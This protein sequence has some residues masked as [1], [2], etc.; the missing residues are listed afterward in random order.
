M[1]TQSPAIMMI[2]MLAT[3]KIQRTRWVRP[4]LRLLRVAHQLMLE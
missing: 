3:R 2:S 4:K 1:E